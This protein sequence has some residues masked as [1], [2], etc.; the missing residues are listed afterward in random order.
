MKKILILIA[1]VLFLSGCGSVEKNTNIYSNDYSEDY[2]VYVDNALINRFLNEIKEMHDYEFSNVYSEDMISFNKSIEYAPN[3]SVF[4]YNYL[5]DEGNETISLSIL[6]RVPNEE[7]DSNF[8]FS[9]ENLLKLIKILEPELKDEDI[10]SLTKF[11]I[12]DIEDGNLYRDSSLMASIRE[13]DYGKTLHISVDIT[14][15]IVNLFDN[16]LIYET[17]RNMV[18]Y[19]TDKSIKTVVD[20][21]E[22]KNID[23]VDYESRSVLLKGRVTHVNPSNDDLGPNEMN[24]T[25]TDE[26]NNSIE[27]NYW[28]A[29]ETY[30]TGDYVEFSG[31]HYS[32]SP[33]LK[34]KRSKLIR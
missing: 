1:G 20:N 27:V 29:N 26:D 21:I 22:S 5:E 32:D 23:F 25:L 11:I 31:I 7:N 6:E 10:K 34:A 16:D 17:E 8:I 30:N 3:F 15:K 18:D 13:D 14:D 28:P 33:T 12:N 4:I 24:Y 9:D 2:T 19:Y